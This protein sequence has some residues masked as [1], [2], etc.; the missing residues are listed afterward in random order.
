MTGLREALDTA[1][2]RCYGK[3]WD[4]APKALSLVV[5]AIFVEMILAFVVT[6][7]STLVSDAPLRVRAAALVLFTLVILLNL[8]LAALLLRGSRLAWSFF[9]AV[10]AGGL[11]AVTPERPSM[12]PGYVLTVV[13]LVLLLLPS[14][15]RAVWRQPPEYAADYEALRRQD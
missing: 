12:V 1:L 10:S 9:A 5:A 8:G 15:I 6:L 13:L 7:V 2:R 4:A 14:T 11:A 3:S